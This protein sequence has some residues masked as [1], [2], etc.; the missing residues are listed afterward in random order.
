MSRNIFGEFMDF[1]FKG[2]NPFKIQ[3]EFDFVLLPEFL[4]QIMS[5]I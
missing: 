3:T 4:I 5:G 2:L 1:F